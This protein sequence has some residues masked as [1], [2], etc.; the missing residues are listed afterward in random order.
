MGAE[1][2]VIEVVSQ[3][4]RE[5]YLTEEPKPWLVLQAAFLEIPL[6]P[7]ET[8][9]QRI[10]NLGIVASIYGLEQDTDT[11]AEVALEASLSATSV[12]QIAAKLPQKLLEL[13]TEIA[14]PIT[15]IDFA[16]EL[17]QKRQKRGQGK[18]RAGGGNRGGEFTILRKANKA[19]YYASAR[20]GLDIYF[21]QMARHSL[22]TAEQEVD[23][24]KRGEA[25]RAAKQ[26]LERGS[27]NEDQRLALEWV[28]KMGAAADQKMI[29]SNLRLVVSIAKRFTNRGLSLEDL[30]QAGNIGLQTAVAKFDHRRGYKFSTY[31]TWWVRQAVQREVYSTARSIRIPIHAEE[32]FRRI[33]QAREALTDELQR[34]PTYEEIARASGEKVTLVKNLYEVSSVTSLD[35]PLGPSEEVTLGG[36]IASDDVIDSQLEDLDL[37]D[38]LLQLMNELTD[39]EKDIIWL[40]FGL[41][42]GKSM[43]LNEIGSRFGLTRERI[44]Q[45]EQ[46]ALNKLKFQAAVRQQLI[47]FLR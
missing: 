40:R 7:R 35:K 10:R 3:T 5:I 43:P 29:E 42:D 2:E 46:R 16:R 41:A 22:L 32:A 36:M 25:G 45:I 33:N 31:A 39:R 1:L 27:I 23:L 12:N 14:F 24:A 26:M 8:V 47:E 44:R 21:R 34:E 18:L 38:S 17:D 6:K 28:E 30:I 4:P 13:T 9:E 15:V 19:P 11:V 37:R 20:E